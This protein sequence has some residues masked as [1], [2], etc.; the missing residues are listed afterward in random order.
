MLKKISKETKPYTWDHLKT[1]KSGRALGYM[2]GPW[3]GLIQYLLQEVM[4]FK[5]DLASHDVDVQ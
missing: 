1:T 3:S 2:G 5:A 4:T